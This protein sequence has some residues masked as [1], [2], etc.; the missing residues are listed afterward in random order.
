MT[1]ITI[2]AGG[3][4]SSNTQNNNFEYLDERITDEVSDISTTLT[5]KIT[6]FCTLNSPL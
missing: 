5:G 2:Q 1:L 3:E 4:A 6:S